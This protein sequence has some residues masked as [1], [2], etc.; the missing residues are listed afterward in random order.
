V[1]A[2][3]A[4]IINKTQLSLGIKTLYDGCCS[5]YGFTL[6]PEEQRIVYFN[7]S[8]QFVIDWSDPVNVPNMYE[9]YQSD[10][11]I[12]SDECYEIFYTAS[13][14]FSIVPRSGAPA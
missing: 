4:T 6:A 1:E 8:F 12:K 10:L 13:K 7:S 5:E 3:Q 11:L 2:Y 9:L 14:K